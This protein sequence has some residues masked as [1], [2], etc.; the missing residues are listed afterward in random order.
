MKLRC[1]VDSVVRCI[2][3]SDCIQRDC[4]VLSDVLVNKVNQKVN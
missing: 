2:Y 4:E 3:V 1:L